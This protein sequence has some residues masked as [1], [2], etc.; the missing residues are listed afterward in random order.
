VEAIEF[1]IT[2]KK[3]AIPGADE[4]VRCMYSLI[5]RTDKAI[6]E[7]VVRAF[8]QLYLAPSEE[9][10][11]QQYPLR[12]ARSLIDHVKASN[13]SQL[14]SFEQ[15]IV[16]LTKQV[17][18]CAVLIPVSVQNLLHRDCIS[19]LWSFFS[20][21]DAAH[22]SESD[23]TAAVQLLSMIGTAERR[24]LDS[25]QQLL[26]G[27]GLGERADRDWTFARHV[28]AALAKMEVR[29]NVSA[30]V[31]VMNGV[32]S[33]QLKSDEGVSATPVR[34][35]RNHPMFVRIGQILMKTID[36]PTPVAPVSSLDCANVVP[37]VSCVL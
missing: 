32:W 8:E 35:P 15:L 27:Y 31:Y 1:V 6:R 3:F 34:Y 23:S 22:A 19:A 7:R 14:A 29:A 21:T 17:R 18:I 36:M 9:E 12:I 5:W 33:I 11:K 30:E 10:S 2:C 25:N 20:R 16:E 26:T 4:G 37:Q 13:A 24:Y 28:C